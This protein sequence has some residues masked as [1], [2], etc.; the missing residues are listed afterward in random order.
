MWS[1]KSGL[2]EYKFYIYSDSNSGF[3]GDLFLLITNNANRKNKNNW[4]FQANLPELKHKKSS[5][6]VGYIFKKSNLKT[7]M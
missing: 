2:G 7:N 3:F 5:F 6:L 1:G 4:Q